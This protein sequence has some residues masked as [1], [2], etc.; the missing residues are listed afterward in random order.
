MG[1]N[2]KQGLKRGRKYRRAKNGQGKEG[3]KKGQEK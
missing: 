2:S 3:L 1:L